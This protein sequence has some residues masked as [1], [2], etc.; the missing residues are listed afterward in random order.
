[1]ALFKITQD[2]VA[3]NQNNP[4]G[5]VAPQKA[6][7]GV[8]GQFG[9]ELVFPVRIDGY[10]LPGEPVI[11]L[12]GAREAVTTKLNRGKSR[13]A[14]VH[15][16]INLGGYEIKMR[17][18]IYSDADD[19]YPYGDVAEFRKFFEKPGS[20]DIQC[21]YLRQFNITKIAI[22]RISFP[23]VPGTPHSQQ[24][25]IMGYSDEDFELELIED[26]EL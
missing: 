19:G 23:G 18:E 25:E 22:M 8:F 3:A 24:Y 21:E 9:T 4:I 15:E 6:G 10:L 5:F 2:G 11:S 13:V 1:M 17:G 7:S 20:R 16:E 26:E 12:G 14:N